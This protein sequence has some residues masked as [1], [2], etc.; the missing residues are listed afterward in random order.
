MK[1]DI[2]GKIVQKT[3]T[4]NKNGKE[5][6]ATT[7]DLGYKYASPQPNVATEIGERIFTYDENGNQIGWED[8]ESKDFRQLYWDEE[9]RLALISDNGYLNRYVYDASDERVIKSHGGT[10]GVYINGAPIGIVNHSDN[11]YTVY[12]SPYFVFQND[13]FT[14]HYYNGSAR[15][16]SKIGNGQFKNLYHLGVFEITAGGVDYI[17]RQQQI[18]DSKEEYERQLG[19][20]PGPPTMKGISA[21]PAFSGTGYP[22]LG[23]PGIT[24]PRG[25]PKE[26]IFAPAGGPPGAPIQWG[27]KVTNDNIEPGFGFVGNGNIEELLRYFYHSNHLGSTSYI[28]N[29]RGDVTQ[30]IAYIPFGE[31]LTEQHSDWNSPY[32]FNAREL[33]S[34]TGLYYYGK[35]Y[36]DPKVSLW[37]GVDPLAEKYPSISPYVYVANNPVI[38]KMNG[39]DIESALFTIKHKFAK[40]SILF[41]MVTISSGNVPNSVSN[42]SGLFTGPSAPDVETPETES[43]VEDDPGKKQVEDEAEKKPPGSIDEKTEATQQMEET[44]DLEI[45]MEETL[46]L[47]TVENVDAQVEETVSMDVKTEKTQQTEGKEIETPDKKSITKPEPEIKVKSG[48]VPEKV[49]TLKSTEKKDK[50]K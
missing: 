37:L 22:D 3:Q 16:T 15:V 13:R 27:D 20:P 5:Q 50:K 29:A 4:L 2:M 25:W 36:Y 45:Q 46:D 21:D 18:M 34:E 17:Y 40:K 9:N 7:Y 44:L 48:N 24:T 28:T 1:Y 31:T 30:F 43:S 49:T 42:T 6:Q 10:Q 14:K 41:N 35:R 11:N 33:D 32:K 8:K 39:M 26:P 38:D 23:T 19:I 47:E 12:V